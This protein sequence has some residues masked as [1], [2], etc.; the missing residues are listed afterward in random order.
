M[1]EQANAGVEQARRQVWRPDPG[2]TWRRY[3]GQDAKGA[4]A[5]A[6]VD[7]T[8]LALAVK[9]IVAARAM[10]AEAHRIDEGR[11]SRTRREAVATA[12]AKLAL[13]SRAIDEVV[14]RR[15]GE[16]GDCREEV[17][18]SQ[19]PR[20][21]V[22]PLGKHGANQHAGSGSARYRNRGVAYVLARLQRDD[23]ALAARV[24]DGELSAHAAAVLAGI[25]KPR[26]SR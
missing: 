18:S 10:L 4:P 9:E 15:G 20:L 26:A 16:P 21:E 3:R 5:A 8:D 22:R 14:L 17:P 19:P 25:R 2:T 11:K 23:P 24:L 6:V 7:D 1:S 13:A 12:V